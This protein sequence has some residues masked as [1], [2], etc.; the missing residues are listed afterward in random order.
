M[1]YKQLNMLIELVG[2]RKIKDLEEWQ[3]K[4]IKGDIKS[5]R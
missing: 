1:S 4:E 2:D 3:I 5:G